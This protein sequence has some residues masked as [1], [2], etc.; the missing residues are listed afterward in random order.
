MLFPMD[1][2][3]IT[4]EDIKKLRSFIMGKIN[5]NGNSYN[6]NN[7]SIC[8]GKI[9]VDG[10]NVTPKDETTI[11]IQ[12]DGNVERIDAGSFHVM[13]V[14]GN[15]GSIKSAS[16]DIEVNGNVEGDVESMSGDIDVNGGV[17]GNCKTM[18]GDINNG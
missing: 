8:N 10:K 4:A 11:M 2:P 18:S 17:K 16:G 3:P 12:V 14:R 9:I 1:M 15:V 5:V 7:I 6:G 13:A